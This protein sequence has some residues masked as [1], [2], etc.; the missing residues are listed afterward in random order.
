M[1]LPA[2][3]WLVVGPA[4]LAGIIVAVSHVPLGM[5][6]LRRGI[7]FVDL[8]IAQIATL[9][10]I[11]VHWMQPEAVGWETQLGAVTA[12]LL[13]AATLTAIERRW[14][15]VQEALIGT[16]FVLAATGAI[17][18]LAK[19][20]HGG[21]ELQ[22]LLVGQ[23]LWVTPRDLVI[24][25]VASLA[26]AAVWILRAPRLPGWAFYV[27]FA[28]A[29]TLSVQLVGVYLVFATLIIPALAARN[30]VPRRQLIIGYSVA[31]CGYG[32]GLA[33]S[34][35]TDLP[36]GALIVWSLAACGVAASILI[37]LCRYNAKHR[38]AIESRPTSA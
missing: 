31:I 24:G 7:V 18:L 36:S 14:P 26:I 34:A 13:G 29:V 6:V 33:V 4:L 5:Q 37:A 23:I 12:A 2:I 10:V 35:L 8:A 30:A 16:L 17:L 22:N 32:S 19:N 21:E 38:T 9:G 1:T 28:I 20:P 25:G 15:D 27:L 11:A 3:D